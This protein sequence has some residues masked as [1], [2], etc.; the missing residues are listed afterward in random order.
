MKYKRTDSIANGYWANAASPP[1]LAA[2]PLAGS[3]LGGEPQDEHFSAR[4]ALIL[5]PT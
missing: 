5:A 4:V 2:D 1:P 3:A